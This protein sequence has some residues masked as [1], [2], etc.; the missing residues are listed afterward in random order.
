[1]TTFTQL[2]ARLKNFLRGCLLVLDLKECLVECATLCVKSE[3]ILMH[4]AKTQLVKILSIGALSF[5][6]FCALVAHQIQIIG[7]SYFLYNRISNDLWWKHCTIKRNVLHKLFH[8]IIC[9]LLKCCRIKSGVASKTIMPCLF[10]KAKCWETL[11]WNKDKSTKSQLQ[12][13]K[14][15]GPTCKKV[16]QS[17]KG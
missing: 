1:M 3:V 9:T 10:Y 8:P 11:A 4:T 17:T 6:A 13:Q 12:L 15:F 7:H 14:I 2:N 16:R 5:Y